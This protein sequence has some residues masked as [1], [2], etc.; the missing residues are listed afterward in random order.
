M[1]RAKGLGWFVAGWG[2]GICLMLWLAAVGSA[3][4]APPEQTQAAIIERAFWADTT[5]QADLAS[6]QSQGY[7]AFSDTFSQGYSP[8]VHWIRLRIAAH[9]VPMALQVGPAWL[10]YLTLYDP[11]TGAVPREAGDHVEVNGDNHVLGGLL[12]SFT[13]APHATERDVWLRLDSTSSHRASIDLLPM[14][15][16]RHAATQAVAWVSGYGAFLL[17]SLVAL[18][19]LWW[20]RRD[21]VLRIYLWRHGVFTY[22]AVSYLGLPTLL[23]GEVLPPVFFDQAF[24]IS[25]IAILPMSIYFDRA[26]MGDYHPNR[27]LLKGFTLFAI[28][29]WLVLAVFLAGWERQALQA[30][31]L[32]L[33]LISAF[34]MLTAFTTRRSMDAEA[35]IPRWVMQG[36]YTSIFISLMVGL[37]AILGWFG[38]QAWATYGLIING[39]IGSMLMA[40]LLVMRAIR[41]NRQDQLAQ[42][43]LQSAQQAVAF[44]Q[45]RRE[46]Q[47]T[48][49]HMLMHE[50][51]TPLSVVSLALGAQQTR[52]DNL[53]LAGRAVQEMKSIIDRCT[54]VDHLAHAS[55]AMITQAVDLDVLVKDVAEQL[56]ELGQRL[57]L[58]TSGV[59]FKLVTDRKFFRMIVH[60]LLDNAMR[61]SDPETTVDL[62]TQVTEKRW[63]LKLS[64][65][66]GLAGWPDSEK[67]FEKYYRSPG[68]QHA[69]GSGLGLHLSQ[70]LARALGGGLDYVP[71]AHRVEFV[72]WLPLNPH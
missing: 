56:P 68:A 72:F 48:F 44:E 19:A 25:T 14:G 34:F 6:A 17:F 57:A 50:L 41:Q 20:S 61:Y 15:Q 62:E 11:A 22:Y 43:A 60:N 37:L 36:Y 33:L 40:A 38:T 10:D 58:Q 47:S 1:W 9:R 49:L 39:L 67:L 46:E 63:I 23:W 16:A 69:S 30:N 26:F 45:Q 27:H 3:V 66:P 51:K 52:Q 12:P 31:V 59:A 5:R 28:L 64:N 71:S 8:A 24:S 29:G 21:A 54:L 18:W 7:T 2:L 55:P 13:L 53:R 70:Q 35:L 32:L 65:V 4:A 42:L